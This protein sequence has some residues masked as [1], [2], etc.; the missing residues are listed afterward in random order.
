MALQGARAIMSPSQHT[1]D[2]QG[3][4]FH[5]AVNNPLLNDARTR[6]CARTG[7]DS[8]LRAE[9]RAGIVRLQMLASNV[10]ASIL[11]A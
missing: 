8:S 2:M 1:P 4:S 6:A 9:L 10:A 11:I 7:E 5:V 3:S